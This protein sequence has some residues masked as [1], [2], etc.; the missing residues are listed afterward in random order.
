MSSTSPGPAGAQYP[1]LLET[2]VATEQLLQGEFLQVHRD[3]VEIAGQGLSTR[4]Y[5]AHPGAVMII[6]QAADGRLILERQFRYP[7]G[8]V[9]IEFPAG[10][11]D[12]GE[13]SLCCAQRELREET[14]YLAGEWAR[15]GVLHPCISYSTEFIDIWFARSLVLSEQQLDAGEVLDVF[16]LTPGE[17]LDWCG[18]GDVTDAKTLTGALWLQNVMSGAWTL[19]WHRA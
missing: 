12:P 15:A 7:M 13:S 2:R 18:R 10:K 19:D 4:E 5:I 16:T 8:R 9:M 6:A 3:T 1:H 11:L 14:G 17:L